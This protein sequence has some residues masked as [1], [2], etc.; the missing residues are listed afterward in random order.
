MKLKYDLHT[1]TVWSHGK[2]T[3]EDNVKEALKKGLNKIA[4]TDHGPWHVS[5]GIRDLEG[6]FAAIDA[7]KKKYSGKIEIL[8]GMELNLCSLDG[9]TDSFT[10]FENRADILIMGFHKFTRPKDMRSL[11]YFYF[12]GR[13]NTVKNTDAIVKALYEN[14]LYILTHPGYA[15]TV[16]YSE[17]A[18]ACAKT[19]T[20]FEINEKHT[21]L[22]EK[23]IEAAAKEGCKFIISSDAHV[24]ENVGNV[25]N[26]INKFLSTG[27]PI[28]SAVNLGE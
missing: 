6:Y 4:I 21:E 20:L 9:K 25:P 2:G 19:N 1:H 24:S 15:F 10:G 5:Y 13:K 7:A 3:V 11:A 22:D 12:T 27:L 26:A 8:S 23:I 14:N 17:V 28:N 16:D 18:K